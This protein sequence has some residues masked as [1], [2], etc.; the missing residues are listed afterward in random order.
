MITVIFTPT[1]IYMNMPTRMYTQIPKIMIMATNTGLMIM[2]IRG[3]SRS[4]I[5]MFIKANGEEV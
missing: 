5:S 2:S 1:N 4:L 3:M